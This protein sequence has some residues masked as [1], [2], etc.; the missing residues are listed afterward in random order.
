MLLA[1][2]SWVGEWSRLEGLTVGHKG[3]NGGEGTGE[4]LSIQKGLQP[5]IPLRCKTTELRKLGLR[6]F[7]LCVAPP[8]PRERPQRAGNLAKT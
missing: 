6:R 8:L 2:P 4:Q 3:K 7:T 1:R 5:K